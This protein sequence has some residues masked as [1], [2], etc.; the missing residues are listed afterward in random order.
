MERVAWENR[1]KPVHTIKEILLREAINVQ[2]EDK[3]ICR[4]IGENGAK[5]IKDG[6]G[7][8]TH[9]NAG[10]LATADYGTALAVMFKAKENGKNLR[11][12]P[13]KPVHFCKAH[14]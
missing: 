11:S 6:D 2:N 3:S 7:V 12:T 5:F 9:C 14:D 4:Q 10:G 13:T 8:L 1:D